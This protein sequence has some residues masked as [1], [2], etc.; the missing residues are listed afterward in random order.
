MMLEVT[1]I[2]NPTSQKSSVFAK[3]EEEDE[4]FLQ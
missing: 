4:I 2:S 3:K 1:S